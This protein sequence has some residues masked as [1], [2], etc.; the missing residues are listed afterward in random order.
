MALPERSE[1]I[2]N[3]LLGKTIGQGTFGKV[4]LALHLL[5][6]QQVAIKI[7]NK[8]TIK[9]FHDEE[10]VQR[11]ID[12]LKQSS[13]PHL[14]QL[15]EVFPL[16][17]LSKTHNTFILSQNLHLKE[18]CSHSYRNQKNWMNSAWEPYSSNSY[19][20]LNIYTEKNWPT[21]TSSPKIFCLTKP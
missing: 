4:K 19:Q 7:L 9:Q 18:S 3:Y 1:R 2:Q 6:H 12:I 8:D 5:T 11:E 14:I 20:D 16:F 15:F 13:H 21:E 10:R 17:R